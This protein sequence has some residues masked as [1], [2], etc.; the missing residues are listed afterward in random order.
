MIIWAVDDP[1]TPRDAL[2]K[3]GGTWCAD[4]STHIAVNELVASLRLAVDDNDRLQRELAEA[5]A[6]I[7][8]VI[9]A[10]GEGG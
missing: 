5:R 2:A 6:Y 3:Y 10:P 1:P 7:S 8:A 9:D 4:S